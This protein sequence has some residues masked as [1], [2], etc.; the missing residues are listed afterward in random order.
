MEN[1]SAN[2][3][4]RANADRKSD[5]NSISFLVEGPDYKTGWQIARNMVRIGGELTSVNPD[6]TVGDTITVAPSEYTVRSQFS[7]D[8]RQK[9]IDPPTVDEFLAYC[10]DNGIS[11]TKRQRAAVDELVASKREQAEQSDETETDAAA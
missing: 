1:G 6:G 5:G 11:V 3:R 2:H 10:D 9:R 4:Y 7:L 8:K